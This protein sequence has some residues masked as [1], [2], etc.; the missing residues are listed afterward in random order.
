MEIKLTRLTLENFKGIKDFILWPEDRCVIR[1]QNAS[2]K[3][4]LMDA[5]LWLLFNKDSQGKADFALKT[6]KDGQEIPNIEHTVEGVF[7]IDGN[8]VKLKKV[9]KEK[10]TK[11]RGNS[12]ADFTGH[13]TE[14]YIDGVPVQKKDWDQQIG[15]MIDEET[16][17]LLTSPTYFNSLHWEKRRALLLEVCGDL[18]DN[19]VIEN[20]KA[21][22]ALPEILGDKSIEAHKKVIAARR[23]EINQRLTEIPSRIDELDKSLTDVSTYDVDA[24]QTQIRELDAEIQTI[25]DD[26]TSANLRKQKAELQAKLS[27]LEVEKEKAHREAT[28]EIDG[29]VEALE[30]ELSAKRRLSTDFLEEITRKENSIKR[31]EEEMA[32]LRSEYAEIA[33]KKADVEDTC[34]TCG[35]ALPKDQVEDAIKKENERQAWR[36]ADINERGKVLKADN[37]RLTQEI[38]A[39]TKKGLTDETEIKEIEAKIKE[40]KALPIHVAFDTRKIDKIKNELQTIENALSS[41]L[42]PDTSP[43]EEKRRTLQTMIAEVDAAKSTK[44][45][46]EELKTEEKKL[47]AEYEEIEREIFLIEKF[48]VAKA[49]MLDE[50]INSKFELARFK[51]F[52]KQINGGIE[53]ACITLY[54]GV[55]Y[56]L[57]L[58]TGAEINVGLDIIKTLSE[59]YNIKAPVFI[60]HAESVTELLDPGTQTIKLMVDEDYPKMEVTNHE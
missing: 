13:T 19:D 21:L 57:G 58:N 30:K 42:S 1:G 25:R 32:R 2:G 50:K 24:I 59:H 54:A 15:D 37:A 53:R 12:Q 27:E 23:K 18:S 10:Y 6:L 47:A 55:P 35:Q 5:F 29:K 31:N 41:N 16:F 49:N 14:H 34:P 7:Q 28:R 4:T 39:I 52:E 44:A 17:K 51:L 56:G 60:D 46:I 26:T 9:L 20:D 36:L 38:E 45:R 8:A 11:K 43:L 40:L 22:V 33:G 48:D 3:T